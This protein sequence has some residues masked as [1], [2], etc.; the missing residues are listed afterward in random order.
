MFHEIFHLERFE[1]AEITSIITQDWKEA[2]MN[3]MPAWR[4]C[5]MAVLTWT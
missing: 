4:T 1:I 5:E 3:A 2:E